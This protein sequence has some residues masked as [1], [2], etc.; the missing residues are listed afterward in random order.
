MAAAGVGAALLPCLVGASKRQLRRIG[1]AVLEVTGEVWLA[2]APQA[3]LKARVRA[4]YDFLAAE[5]ERRRAWFEG[6]TPPR[7]DEPQGAVT[8][9]C[10]DRLFVVTSGL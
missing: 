8:Q 3:L 4:L 6:E 7:I 1:D 10:F 9:S 5:I 2:A